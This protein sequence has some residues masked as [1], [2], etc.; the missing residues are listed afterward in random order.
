M[1]PHRLSALLVTGLLAACAGRPA[2]ESSPPAQ[3]EIALPHSAV[4]AYDALSTRFDRNGAFGVVTFMDQYW[5]IAGNPGYNASIDHIRDLLAAAGFAAD[6]ATGALGHV[7]VEEFKNGSRGWD[8]QRGSVAIEGQADG[9]VLSREKDRVSLAINS[10][11]TPEGGLR[12]PLVDVGRGASDADFASRELKGAVVLG[13][14]PLDR[15]WQEAVRKRGAAGVISTE[16]AR[17]IRPSEPAAMS[18]EQKDVLQWGRIPYDGAARSFGFKASWR[19][20]NRLREALRRGPVTVRV[21]IAST[22]YDGPNRSL[23]AEIPGRSKP[24]ERIVMVAHVQEPGANDDASGCAT[25]YALARALLDAIRSGALPPPERTLTFLWVDEIRGSREWIEAHPVEARAVQY[26]FSMDMTGEDTA[27][28][29]GTFLIE[30]QADP[31]A[32]WPRPSD[33]HS[34]WGAGSVKRESIKGSLLNDV[35]L[36]IA[37]HRARQT[38]WVVRTNPYEGGSDHTVFAA[39]GVPSLLNWHFTDRYYH[40]NQDR[41]DKTSAREMEHVGVTVAT[42]AWFL[43]SADAAD[44]SAVADLLASAATRRLALERRQG[45][46]LIAESGDRLKAEAVEQQVQQAWI[47][48]YGEAFD[49]VLRLPAAGAE[50]ALRNKVKAARQSLQQD[51]FERSPVARVKEASCP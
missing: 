51:V 5:R 44:A 36:A 18:E 31:T 33:P 49:S 38:D 17:Y 45:A 28:T 4:R 3:P 27:K 10:H 29:G 9:V 50:E 24:A 43:A 39:A 37:Q 30:K 42:S 11:S 32:V 41:P 6:G 8:Y 19:S 21:D 12:A 2:V 14:G 25:L 23:V 1:N 35:H 20:A 40:T 22:F 48:W 7:R 46:T 26:M 47:K 16:V 15:L 13:D 34:E